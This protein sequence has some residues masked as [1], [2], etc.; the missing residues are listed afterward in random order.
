[1]LRNPRDDDCR[2][3]KRPTVIAGNSLANCHPSI[4]MASCLD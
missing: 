1:M 2:V 4:L 3:Y